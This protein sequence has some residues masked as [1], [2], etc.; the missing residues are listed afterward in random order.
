[1]NKKLLRSGAIILAVLAGLFLLANLGLNYWLKNNLP[2]Y[3]KNNSDYKISYTSLDVA[4]G[5]GN[6]VATG[7]SINSKNPQNKN[8]IG[9]AGTMDKLE[10]SRLGIYDAVFNKRINSS[11]LLLVNPNLNVVLAKPIDDRTGK[12]RNPF[13]F[14]NIRIENGNITMFRHNKQKFVGV[15][16][17]HLFVENLQMT[18]ESVKT[19]LPVVFDK[20][21]INGKN[22][23]YRPDD[24]YVVSAATITTKNG[25][26]NIRD[27]KL[28]PL[29]THA[30]FAKFYPNRGNL[31][32]FKA[33][34][35]DFQD[36]VLKN[37]KVSLSNM[38]FENPEIK[39]FSSK[40]QVQNQKKFTYELNLEDIVLNNA[41]VEIVKFNGNK[42]FSAEN[43]NL[44]IH[45]LVMDEETAKGNIPFSYEKFNVKGKNINYHSDTHSVVTSSFAISPQAIDL[46][47]L[48]VKPTVATSV[49]TLAN[50]RAVQ[51]ALKMDEWKF[52]NNKLKLNAQSALIT[53]LMGSISSPKTSSEKKPT[54]EG[55]LFPLTVKNLQITGPNFTY[56]KGGE[57]S[58]LNNL[59]LKVQNLEMNAQTAKEG[60]PFKTGNFSF[61]TSNF[62]RRISQFYTVNAGLLKLNRGSLQVNN[63]S[64][65]PMV[66]RT[67]FIRMISYEKDLYDIKVN[68]IT[69][70]GNWDL[71]SA[72]KHLY[73]TAVNLSG[74][75]ANIFR[76][77]V[78]KDDLS[79]KPMYT[80]LLRKIKFPVIVSN[81]DVK[82]SVLVYEE[83]TKQSEGPG[84]L[85][86]GNLN[87]NIKNLNSGKAA[88]KPTR[89]P[90]TVR[91]S[92][93]NAS[94]MNV[95]WTMDTASK[96]DAFTIAGNIADLPASRINAFIEP[97]LKAR[98]TG[99]IQDLIF[100]FRG[101]ISGLSGTLNMKHKDLQVS[102]LK[103]T[104][105]KKKLLSA[106]V[107][108]F[109]KSN[110]GTYPESVVV[111][112]VKRDPAKSFFNLFWQGIQEGLKKTLI[113][114]NVENTEKTVRNTVT[115]T[116]ATVKDTKTSVKT[117]VQNAK[118]KINAA[119]AEDVE[120]KKGNLLQ[121]VFR[122]K[123][124]QTD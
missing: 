41:T 120:P 117:K 57:S 17:L 34:E 116:K 107:N 27:F 43:L 47:N 66:S 49:K 106:V 84:K 62:S 52:E 118:D 109:V 119:K 59:N 111:D 38:R 103:D 15:E 50:F 64:M 73:A 110:S 18:E 74:V 93:M 95:Q 112:N 123:E 69:A 16:D 19:K 76:S 53:G 31:F 1:L 81:L 60:I 105:E 113:G 78:P 75:N 55:I 5:T 115:D 7:I 42:F 72:D 82:N 44:D 29:I 67:Q 10:I 86:F 102:L 51:V 32:D 28:T 87:M 14:K 8:V 99:T 36:I 101:T 21:D 92:F 121:R 83:D 20:Y 48:T 100:N 104:G 54:Y 4:L 63:F 98:A 122:K 40:P 45:K 96:N 94:P 90:I 108:V 124:K 12:K 26:M 24:V 30:Q 61:T 79:I 89:I 37:N 114:A 25:L 85:T 2:G 65:R 97:Y 77:K 13:V 68:Q 33:E 35:L 58:T 71:I 22:F 56:S 91:C 46:R 23:Y 9:L 88:G 39:I 80:E 3:I 11:D 70:N 6:I